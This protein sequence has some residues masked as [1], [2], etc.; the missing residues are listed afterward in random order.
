[1]GETCKFLQLGNTHVKTANIILLTATFLAGGTTPAL[2]DQHSQSVP[3][4]QITVVGR[5]AD[6]INYLHRA[7][8]TKLDFGGTVLL[9]QARGG[10][11]IQSRQGAVDIRAKFENLEAPTRFGREYLTYVLWAVTPDGRPVNLGQLIADNNNRA[12]IRT[13]TE[14]QTFALIVTAE[15]YYAVTQPSELV[16]L[17]NIVRPD[18]RGAV[19]PISA[20][21]ELLRRSHYT[22]DVMARDV[23]QT[24][25][26]KVSLS[27]YET[28]L[29]LYQARNAVQLAKA[30]GAARHALPTLQR[31][32]ELLHQAEAAYAQKQRSRSIIVVARSATQTAE[33]ARLIAVR[34]EEG[35]KVLA[36]PS[37]D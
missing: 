5:T 8:P 1:V 6:A 34:R 32:E 29:E 23:S 4:Y 11:R 31:A 15:P 30:S 24:E 25:T 21:V 26:H 22:Y 3:L 18:T 17:E 12:K 13:A 19:E 9:P 35:E 14:L 10:A 20:K 37:A 2:A 33:D 7:G 27:E 28:L 36:E 16:V